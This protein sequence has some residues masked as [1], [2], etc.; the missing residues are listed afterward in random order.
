MSGIVL[1]ILLQNG[2]TGFIIRRLDIGD[3]SPFETGTVAFIQRLD[4]LRRTVGGQNDLF[5]GGM[6]F[7]KGM[8]E[9]FLGG[10]FA[11]DELDIVYKQD[12]DSAVFI[13]QP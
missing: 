9:F 1:R 2:H 10:V 13:T 5:A 3:Q 4:F 7:I 8:E 12:I 6:Q 11:D